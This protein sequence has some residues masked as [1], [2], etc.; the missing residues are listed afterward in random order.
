MLQ[1]LTY[2]C[3][4]DRPE[5]ESDSESDFEGKSEEKVTL[6]K[7]VLAEVLHLCNDH[8]KETVKQHLSDL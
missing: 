7:K 1:E 8:M 4:R 3:K 6:L 5:S 2:F